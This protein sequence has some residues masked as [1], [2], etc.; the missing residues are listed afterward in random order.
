[1]F[2]QQYYYPYINHI[3]DPQTLVRDDV[4]KR[5]ISVAKKKAYANGLKPYEVIIIASIIEKEVA[6]IDQPKAAQT[7]LNRL[8]KPMRLQLDSTLNYELNS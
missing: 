3:L 4:Y 1:M 6:P 2:H 5:R 7:I 8:A